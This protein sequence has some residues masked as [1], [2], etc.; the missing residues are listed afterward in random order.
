VIDPQRRRPLP[1]QPVIVGVLYS[2]PS[3]SRGTTRATSAGAYP[4]YSIELNELVNAPSGAW[5]TDL[6]DQVE[7]LSDSQNPTRPPLIRYAVIVPPG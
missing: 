1:G 3:A 6:A 2:R 7:L 5:L 4:K